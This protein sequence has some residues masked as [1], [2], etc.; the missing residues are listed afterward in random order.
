MKH[1]A[2]LCPAFQE[3]IDTIVNSFGKYRNITY[4]VQGI[5][6][7]GADIVIRLNSD[8]V[9]RYICIQIQS[10]DHVKKMSI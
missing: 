1:N 8:E 10:Q 7:K 4:D 3:K 5:N 6:D 9:I 2:D